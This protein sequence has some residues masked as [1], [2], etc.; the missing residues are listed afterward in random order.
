MFSKFITNR[1]AQLREQLATLS[2]E[3][4]QAVIR[5]AL[6]GFVQTVVLLIMILQ[7][8]FT[9]LLRLF[10][11]ELRASLS[12]LH[13]IEWAVYVGM[14]SILMQSILARRTQ[15]LFTNHFYLF[16]W[17]LGKPRLITGEKIQPVVITYIVF[18]LIMV[19][20]VWWVRVNGFIVQPTR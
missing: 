2:V 15:A 17:Y 12:F 14:V 20:V 16:G 6:L 3:Q 5:Q 9:G 11:P 18:V 10:P 19:A 4:Q 8:V 7:I 13:R 1:L